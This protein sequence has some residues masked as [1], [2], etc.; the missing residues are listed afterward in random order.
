[1]LYLLLTFQ[2]KNKLEFHI[3]VMPNATCE[4]DR[5]WRALQIKLDSRECEGASFLLRV[6]RT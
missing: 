2:Q 3:E 6:S 4:C 5:N 1:M